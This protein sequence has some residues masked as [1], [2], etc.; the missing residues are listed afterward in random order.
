MHALVLPQGP[1][2]ASY[3]MAA[4]PALLFAG[5]MGENT[6]LGVCT[7]RLGRRRRS[8]KHLRGPRWRYFHRSTPRNARR[9]GES[10]SYACIP[11]LDSVPVGVASRDAGHGVSMRETRAFLKLAETVDAHSTIRAH[12]DKAMRRPSTKHGAQCRLPVAAPHKRRRWLTTSSAVA[13][14]PGAGPGTR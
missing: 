13:A 2:P 12:S 14:V 10:S 6:G 9:A 1:V 5:T 4:H 3:R 7:M 8:P 11:A